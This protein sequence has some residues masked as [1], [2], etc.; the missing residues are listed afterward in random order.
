V[1]MGAHVIRNM[2]V[3]LAMLYGPDSVQGAVNRGI[4]GPANQN[5]CII[6]VLCVGNLVDEEF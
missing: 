4:V 3:P 5:G 6:R 1:Q 2:S